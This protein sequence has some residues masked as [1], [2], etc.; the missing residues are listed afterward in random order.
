MAINSKTH[1]IKIVI[2]YQKYN[3]YNLNFIKIL[4]II[5]ATKI[6]NHGIEND[7]NKKKKFV[8]KRNLF[9]LKKIY[10]SMRKKVK[11]YNIK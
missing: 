11:K 1:T 3:K 8:K 6:E 9:T 4:K 7:S 5:I 2:H 10:L